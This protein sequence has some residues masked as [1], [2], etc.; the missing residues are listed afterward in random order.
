VKRDADLHT[1]LGVILILCIIKSL[2]CQTWVSLSGPEIT[3]NTA[4]SSD[5]TYCNSDIR[6]VWILSAGP[7]FE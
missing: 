4:T 1:G 5:S 7:D 3:Y 6:T 2:S